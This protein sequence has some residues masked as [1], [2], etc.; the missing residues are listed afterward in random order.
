[1]TAIIILATFAALIGAYALVMWLTGDGGP[2]S[3]MR[4]FDEDT[5]R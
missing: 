4:F 5:R 3:V 1:M 2:V